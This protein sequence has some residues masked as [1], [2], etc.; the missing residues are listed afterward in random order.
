MS[1]DVVAPGENIYLATLGNSYCFNS[2]T[3]FAAPHVSAIAALILSLNADLT[4]E[5]VVNIIE[6]TTQNLSSAYY[7][8]ID[9]RINGKWNEEFGYGLIDAYAA[10]LAAQPKYIQNQVYQSGQEVYEYAPEITAGYAVTDSKRHGDV[11]LEAGSDVT[12]RGMDRVVLKP[13]FHAKAGC[14]LHIN[15]DTPT[16]IQ[17]ASSPQRVAPRTSSAPTDN[18]NYTNEEFDKNGLETVASNRIVSTSI[19]T[20][21]GQLIQTILGGQ[22]DATHLPNGMYILQYRMSD[23]SVRSEKIANNK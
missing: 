1:L 4:R 22:H 17:T 11:V 14:K 6:I 20:I 5:E 23:G 3:S 16:T 21:S 9:N 15:V 2:G 18:A 19:Y 10:V 13:G 7:P 8:T 12:L